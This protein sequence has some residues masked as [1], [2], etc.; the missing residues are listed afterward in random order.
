MRKLLTIIAVTVIAVAVFMIVNRQERE[1]SELSPSLPPVTDTVPEKQTTP[2]TVTY[3]QPELEDDSILRIDTIMYAKG[4][5]FGYSGD[6]SEW[7]GWYFDTIYVGDDHLLHY[8]SVGPSTLKLSL[9]TNELAVDLGS[10]YA[11]RKI[12]KF[13]NPIDGF[14]RFRKSYTENL[15]S[16]TDDENNT[17]IFTGDFTFIVDYADTCRENAELINRLLCSITNTSELDNTHISK[18]SAFYAGYNTEKNSISDYTGNTM[19]IVAFSDFVADNTFNNWKEVGLCG[20]GAKTTGVL[21]IRARVANQK[22]VTYSKY[23][24]NQVGCGHGMYT[25]TFHTFDLENEKELKNKDIFKSHSLDKVKM[26][27]F[28]VM[29]KDAH[30]QQ[31]NGDDKT[32]AEIESLIEE[33][34]SPS[35]L[36]KGTEWEEPE[37]EFK[38]VLPQGA[39]TKT[40]V[41][42]SFQPYEINCWAAGA[43]HFVVPYKKLM[44][45]LTPEA[46]RL[47]SIAN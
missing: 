13:L 22:Y 3:I 8:D 42:F 41:V 30:Y 29:A 25:Q 37:G 28:E 38:F 45:Y 16:V 33:W 47:I 6:V 15:D 44:P 21:D 11:R 32:A 39:L 7:E 1:E 10:P 24:Y 9:V 14:K 36:L 43:F 20:F 19:D 5:S 27:L 18:L 46:K 12:K 31:W 4:H 34:Q 26:K 35:P 17:M 2:D 23:E 40:G